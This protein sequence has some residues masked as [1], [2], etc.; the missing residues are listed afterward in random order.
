MNLHNEVSSCSG[1][2][3]RVVSLPLNC[4]QPIED[5]D[6]RREISGR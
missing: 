4:S 1:L 2:L 3:R 6:A 5:P